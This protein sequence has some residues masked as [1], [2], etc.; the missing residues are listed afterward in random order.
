MS[1]PR[2]VNALRYSSLFGVICAVYLGIAITLI[3]WCDR[4]L[5]PKPFENLKAAEYLKFSPFGIFST[6]PLIIF[7]YMYQLNMPIIYAELKDRSYSRMNTV[8]I[9]GTIAALIVYVI[10]GVS[11]YLTFVHNTESLMT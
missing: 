5:V 4:D 10:T 2:S 6:V 3:F 7:A 1:L 8:V 11:G 9:R